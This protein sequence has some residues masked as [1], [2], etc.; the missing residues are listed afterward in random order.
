[1]G[2]DVTDLRADDIEVCRAILREGSK[3]FHAAGLLLPARARGPIAALYAFCRVA[4]DAVDLVA[5]DR[6]GA[7][8]ERLAVRLAS[9]YAGTPDDHPVDRA[10]AATVRAHRIPRA[11]PEALIDGFRWDV[12][13][14]RYETFSDVVAYSAR[15]AA[16]VGVM[17]TLIMGERAPHVLDRACDL[18]V[19]MQLTNIARDVGEDAREGRLYLPLAWLRREEIDVDAFLAAPRFEPRIGRVVRRLLARAEQLYARADRGIPMLPR[20]VR[21]AMKAARLVY[22]DIGREIAEADYDSV[23]SRAHTSGARKAVLLA[24]A[25]PA[26]IVPSL[27]SRAEPPLREVRFLVDAVAELDAEDA[28]M[29]VAGSAQRGIRE[30]DA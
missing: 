16:T 14:R 26:T 8:V 9:V 21:T 6:K 13:N 23:T 5:T 19:A 7:A 28:D 18:G 2:A 20:D 10:F 27:P 12:E 15:V 25:L 1:M 24:Q 17:M 11:L 4:D 30:A 22:A 29:R 3:S